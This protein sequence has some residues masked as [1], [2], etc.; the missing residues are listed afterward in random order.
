MTS[1]DIFLITVTIISEA[2][3]FETFKMLQKRLKNCQE[4][5]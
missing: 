2:A 3:N 1:T 4:S 5:M